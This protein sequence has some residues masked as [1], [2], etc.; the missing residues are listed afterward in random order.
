MSPKNNVLLNLLLDG[1]DSTFVADF[2][3]LK[4]LFSSVIFLSP[5]KEIDIKV[6]ELL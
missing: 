2:F 6:F 5:E 3:F 4:Q 1:K